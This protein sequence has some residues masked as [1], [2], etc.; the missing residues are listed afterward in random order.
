MYPRGGTT[1]A[2]I[3]AL[4]DCD[5]IFALGE[6]TGEEPAL[7]LERQCDVPY[8][9]MPLP[10]GIAGTDSFVMGL[11]KHFVS[12]V[13]AELEEERGQ[14]LDV[15]LDAH[16]YLYGK[17]AAI[18][19]DPDTVLGLTAMALEMGMTPRYVLTGTPGAAFERKTNALLAQYDAKGCRVKAGGDLFELHQ[20]LKGEKTDLMLGTTYGKQIA[21][22]EDIPFVRV[23]FPILDRYVHSYM[24]IVGY[25]GALR[26][27]EKITEALLDR[28][29]RDAADEDLEI[30]M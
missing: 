10:M 30:V 21:R 12:A 24:P 28:Q 15:M 29:D 23:G 1:V 4:G 20:W 18:F 26:L 17:T 27:V 16:F 7:T 19:G 8:D 5:K 9:L 22:A 3:I 2:D 11:S 25:R 6:L 13:P 14:L